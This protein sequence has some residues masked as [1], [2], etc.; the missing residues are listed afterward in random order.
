MTDPAA[1]VPVIVT[2]AEPGASETAA[3]LT[4]LGLRP[5]LSPCIELAARNEALPELSDIG[6]LVFTSANGV[7]F[8]AAAN[9]AR[10]LPAWCIG[11]ATASEALREGFSPV[12]QSSGDAH[13]LAH[14]IA[15]HWHAGTPKRLLHV[16]N[17]AAKGA[18]K[19]ELEKEG[20]EVDFRPL[21]EARPASALSPEAA[22]V[23]ASGEPA[24]C[25]IHSRKGAEAFLGVA[26]SL[27]LS[28]TRCVAISDQ[29]ATPLQAVKTGG[30]FAASHPD[31][32][33][34]LE[35]LQKVLAE[36]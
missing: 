15:H 36:D 5:V 8:F 18:L 10:D 22:A 1:A 9:P 19:A 3:R 26:K 7:R 16:A 29:A 11:P 24:V 4:E 25:L 23:L 17:A 20:F 34:L 27:D 35:L 12:H 2:R 13:D 32:N 21:Y 14:Y 31:E 28:K 33:H 6:G 30:V